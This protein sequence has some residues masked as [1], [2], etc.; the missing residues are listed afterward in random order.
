MGNDRDLFL[1][2]VEVARHEAGEAPVQC[3]K[4]IHVGSPFPQKLSN[5]GIMR[6][7]NL[8]DEDVLSREAADDPGVG[9]LL[10]PPRE[11]HEQRVGEMHDVGPHLRRQPGSELLHLLSLVALLAR[12]GR[13]CER[14]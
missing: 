12:E 4:L 3:H 9:G 13:R 1:R 6:R 2:H 7:G 11:A 14:A 5:T 8:L 10:H